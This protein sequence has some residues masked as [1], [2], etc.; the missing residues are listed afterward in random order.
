MLRAQRLMRCGVIATA[1]AEQ[2]EDWDAEEDG[3]WEAPR[4]SN[5][6]C[7][8]APGCGE[9][10]RPMKAN[11]AY[12][13]KWSAPLIDNPAYKVCARATFLNHSCTRDSPTHDV[14]SSVGLI[15]LPDWQGSWHGMTA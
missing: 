2:P 6:K 13:G 9:W 14:L 15:I 7:G 12:K 4:I 11:P 5:P 10:K 3:E 1:D 8:T